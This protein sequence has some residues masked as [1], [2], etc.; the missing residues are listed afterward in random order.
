MELNKKKFVLLCSALISTNSLVYGFQCVQMCTKA[1][2]LP[3]ASTICRSDDS[4]ISLESLLNNLF[5]ESL[6]A[7]APQE[8]QT[9]ADIQ[10]EIE[11]TTPRLHEVTYL[12]D[13]M[14]AKNREHLSSTLASI[15]ATQEQLANVKARLENHIA[16]SNDFN[17]QE[18]ETADALTIHIATPGFDSKNVTVLVNDSE[19]MLL[20]E[21]TR[22]AKNTFS[23]SSTEYNSTT[24]RQSIID[25]KN[26]KLNVGITLPDN[27]D[28]PNH[29]V[30]FGDDEVIVTL[31]FKEKKSSQEPESPTHVEHTDDSNDSDMN[32]SKEDD[33]ESDDEEES[34]EEK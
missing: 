19:K 33:E 25:Y 8:K 29:N 11:E 3:I 21:G 26:G 30:D 10:Q 28:Y 14:H 22:A 2:S 1:E 12:L 24:G 7:T 6:E 27:I 16:T 4:S 18:E 15:D 5:G 34:E 20:L 9:W 17:I 32:T 13:Q 31:P 23:Y